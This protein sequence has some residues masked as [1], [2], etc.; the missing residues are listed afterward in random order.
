MKNL[1]DIVSGVTKRL[2]TDPHIFEIRGKS[3]RITHSAG[4]YEAYFNLTPEARDEMER[5]SIV[6]E[7]ELRAK[8]EIVAAAY[9]EGLAKLK[10]TARAGDEDARRENAAAKWKLAA[11]FFKLPTREEIAVA[12]TPIGE[13]VKIKEPSTV[14]A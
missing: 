9:E 13:V 11:D 6:L 3:Y 4:L 1:R 10:A 8:L 2:A 5:R 12:E 14:N 7:D